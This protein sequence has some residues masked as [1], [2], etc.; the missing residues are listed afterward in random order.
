M[1]EPQNDSQT[2]WLEIHDPEISSEQLMAE[3]EQRVTQ[4]RATLGTVK[5]VFPTFGFVSECPQPP[6]GRSYNPNLY[7]HL[8]QANQM[9]TV[10]VSPLLAP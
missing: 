6:D 3:V 5:P 7:H 4:R 10:D 9:P 2:V 8:R 1:S